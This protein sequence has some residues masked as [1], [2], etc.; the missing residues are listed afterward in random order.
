MSA[1]IRVFDHPWFTIPDDHGSF[2]LDGVPAGAHTL[3]AWHERIGEQRDRVAIRSGQVT[4]VSFTLPV[5]EPA[6]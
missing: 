1:V 2:S 3:V 6:K 4:E 5:L